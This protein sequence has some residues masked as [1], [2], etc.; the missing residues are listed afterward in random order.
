MNIFSGQ[1]RTEQ[2]FPY[3]DVLNDEQHE[4]LD[5]VREPTAK[6]FSEYDPLV[7][8]NDW[9]ID[10]RILDTIKSLG[11]YGMQ[12]PVEYSG[13]GLNNTQYARLG[14][15]M[16]AHDLA[17]GIVL[18][19]HQSIGYKG[20]LLYGTDKQK[21]KYLPDLA[22]GK[23]IA[24]FALTEPSA[25]SDASSIKARAELSEDGSHY[26]LNGSKIWISN[27]GTAEIMTVFAKTPMKTKSGEIKDKVSA[28]IVERS[29][30]G[31]TNGPPENKMGI[32]AS[33]TAEVFFENCKIPKENLLGEVGEGFKVAMNILN[34]GR[35]GMGAALTGTMRACI[36]KATDFANNRLQFGNNLKNFGGIQEKLARMS[37]A[38]YSAESV[39]YMVSGIMDKGHL[40]FQLE[41]AVS[42][43]YASEA[44]WYVCDEAIQIMGGMGYMRETGLEKVLRDIRI[45][46]IFE[47]TN[48]ILRLF[49]ALTG[50]SASQK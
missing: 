41:A 20:I 32:K 25:G 22:T 8:E 11:G 9:K 15:V 5:M 7:A 2:V 33:N 45:F 18:G 31:V 4:I 16:G 46:R 21:E 27:G 50:N 30:G 43:I 42:K 36:A 37:M 14:E 29:F 19:A 17:A 44:A 10:D 40:D 48:D 6:I 12:V 39:A 23:N 38:H 1:L 28:F 34:S 47:G 13:A 49:I 35:F 24:C 3:P 26:V